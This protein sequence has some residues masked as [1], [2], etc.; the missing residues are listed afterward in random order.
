[1]QIAYSKIW[2]LYRK[3]GLLLAICFQ[4]LMFPLLANNIFFLCGLDY[5]YLIA[6][7]Q[8]VSDV[9]AGWNSSGLRLMSSKVKFMRKIK[10]PSPQNVHVRCVKEGKSV[11]LQILFDTDLYRGEWFLGDW[12]S[13]ED[14]NVVLSLCNS[15]SPAAVTCDISLAL[16][17]K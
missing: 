2:L 1:M 17:A 6:R 13:Q 14:C 9:T 5:L 8:W 15:S 4:C 16:S 11:T 7:H 10:P 12:H 3:N